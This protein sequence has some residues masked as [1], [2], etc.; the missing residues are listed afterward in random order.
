[1][2]AFSAAVVPPGSQGQPYK[3]NGQ[4]QQQQP[5]SQQQ[6]GEVGR[7]TPQ[8]LSVADE[9]NEDEVSQLLKDHKEL[10]K[11]AELVLSLYA[12]MWN[13]REVYEGQKVLLREGRSSQAVTE[14]SGTSTLSTITNLP[15]R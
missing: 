1:M 10:R 7:A 13:R 2:P 11:A 3:G 14:Q 4:T 6:H 5:Q 9:M 8:P 12:N 15:R